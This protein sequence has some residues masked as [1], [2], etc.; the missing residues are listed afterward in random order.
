LFV[1]YSE[2]K[3]DGYASLKDGQ[4]VEFEIG[5]CKKGPCATSVVP[6]QVIQQD[7]GQSK[8]PCYITRPFIMLFL[9][10]RF[11]VN[12]NRKMMQKNLS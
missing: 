3:T 1:H 8:K 5:E 11:I 4:K 2:I 10:G 9:L 6:A 12:N 7:L